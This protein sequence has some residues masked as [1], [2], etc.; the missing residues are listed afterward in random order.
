MDATT[1]PLINV[2]PEILGGEPVF[3][4]TRVPVK[5]LTDWLAGGY[6]IEEFL[7]NFPTVAEDQVVRFIEEAGELM[8]ER[9]GAPA[10]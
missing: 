5:S 1:E 8:L 9:H 10:A 2:D 7:D 4:G 6:S 3:M